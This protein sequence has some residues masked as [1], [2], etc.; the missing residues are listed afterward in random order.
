M[1]EDCLIDQKSRAKIRA[2]MFRFETFFNNTI[3][4][5]SRIKNFLA[6]HFALDHLAHFIWGAT[7]QVLVLTDH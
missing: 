5:F 2:S 1:I 4:I 6:P 3:E 7:K